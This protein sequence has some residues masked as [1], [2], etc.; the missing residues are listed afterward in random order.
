MPT[1][2]IAGYKFRFYSSDRLEPPHV[3]VLR[4]NNVAKVWLNPINLQY[5]RGYRLAEMNAILRLT[6]ENQ[7]ALLEAWYEHFSK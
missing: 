4:D 5:N 2:R 1:L 3:H 7:S 6:Y